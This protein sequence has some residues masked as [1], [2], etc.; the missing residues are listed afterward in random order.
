[1]NAHLKF[2]KEKGNVKMVT[3]YLQAHVLFVQKQITVEEALLLAVV[4]RVLF[5]V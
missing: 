5:A 1:M 4:L 3:T 2:L